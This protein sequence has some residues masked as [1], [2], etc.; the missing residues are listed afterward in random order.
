MYLVI[1]KITG[2]LGYFVNLSPEMPLTKPVIRKLDHFVETYDIPSN[3]LLYI[4]KNMNISL[5]CCRKSSRV[6]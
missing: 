6:V 3:T 2:D 1:Y 4:T 5:Q